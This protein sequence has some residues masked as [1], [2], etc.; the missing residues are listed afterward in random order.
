MA[1]K[2]SEIEGEMAKHIPNG[3]VRHKLIRWIDN[4]FQINIEVEVEARLR[5]VV[6]FHTAK[7][8]QANSRTNEANLRC[9]EL[10]FQLRREKLKVR[11]LKAR[12]APTV[13]S[14]CDNSSQ[15]IADYSEELIDWELHRFAGES[16][17]EYRQRVEA[18]SLD[19]WT[20][21][22]YLL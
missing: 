21:E 19:S 18:E 1:F 4:L 5:P 14:A 22:L 8:N 2:T 11:K 16:L 15:D 13:V 3:S 6:D 10:E 12:L 20:V 17:I 7:I 9:D